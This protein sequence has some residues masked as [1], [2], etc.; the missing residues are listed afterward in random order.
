[1]VTVFSASSTFSKQSSQLVLDY[2]IQLRSLIS[3]G[4]LRSLQSEKHDRHDGGLRYHIKA[5]DIVMNQH[6]KY[7]DDKIRNGMQR[8]N[9]VLNKQIFLVINTFNG[10]LTNPFQVNSFF[11][12]WQQFQRFN[13]KERRTIVF[14]R[15]M[16]HCRLTFWLIASILS[17]RAIGTAVLRT[18]AET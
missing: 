6:S 18:A 11:F 16:H 10:N 12:V 3:I 15:V 17:V 4:N 2:M 13:T 8:F 14:F 5:K 9:L 1:M 7:K